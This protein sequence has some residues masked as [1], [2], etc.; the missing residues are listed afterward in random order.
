MRVLILS[1]LF[2]EIRTALEKEMFLHLDHVPIPG[3]QKG[4]MGSFLDA[5][6]PPAAF[7]RARIFGTA[8]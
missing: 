5:K 1:V 3:M 8:S 6:C 4:C 7:L 2:S